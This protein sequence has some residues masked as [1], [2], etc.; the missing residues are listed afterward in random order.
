MSA[1][2]S[3]KSRDIEEKDTY[4]VISPYT[5]G[6]NKEGRKEQS[7]RDGK[8]EGSIK[9][10]GRWVGVSSHFHPQDKIP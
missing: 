9:G 2:V 10:K 4:S 1:R 5:L 8:K 7:E 3:E 6:R